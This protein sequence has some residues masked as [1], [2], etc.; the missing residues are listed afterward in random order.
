V[1]APATMP[2][3]GTATPDARSRD[4]LRSRDRDAR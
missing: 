1:D 3:T 2:A 4:G